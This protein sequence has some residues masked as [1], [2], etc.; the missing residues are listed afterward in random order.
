MH[1]LNIHHTFLPWL[2]I[3][4]FS[5]CA[6]LSS[7]QLR[8]QISIPG[9]IAKLYKLIQSV[10]LN[11]NQHGNLMTLCQV[12]DTFILWL[13]HTMKVD[14]QFGWNFSCKSWNFKEISGSRRAIRVVYLAVSHMM[15][16]ICFVEIL[17]LKFWN[18]LPLLGW[19]Q[20]V[21]P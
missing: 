7:P 14:V 4:H 3:T 16:Q 10:I 18:G 15:N 19:E 11:S 1:A 21:P 6:F 17:W 12:P 13:H 8:A 2:F 9:L 20:E 5:F